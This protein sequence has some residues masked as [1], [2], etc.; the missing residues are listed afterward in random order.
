MKHNSAYFL[1]L[2]LSFFLFLRNPLS[3]TALSIRLIER[4]SDR[5]GDRLEKLIFD[6][7]LEEPMEGNFGKK[8]HA[9]S[10]DAK[11]M[12]GRRDLQQFVGRIYGTRNTKTVTR[13][14]F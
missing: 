3:S 6:A 4:N 7:W 9:D 8:R 13:E 14:Y 12:I 11:I 5:R 10:P 2:P 1:S